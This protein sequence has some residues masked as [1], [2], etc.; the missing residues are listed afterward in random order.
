MRRTKSQ[1]LS[2][3]WT[4]TR[5]DISVPDLPLIANAPSEP[6]FNGFSFAL[7]QQPATSEQ[8]MA[9]ANRMHG[10]GVDNE[11]YDFYLLMKSERTNGWQIP[12]N[13]RAR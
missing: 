2:T 9:L 7:G 8:P 11:T 13:L 12:D 6:C 10:R 3:P 4:F 5:Q 1:T